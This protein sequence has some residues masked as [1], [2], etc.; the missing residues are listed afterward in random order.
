MKKRWLP[1]TSRKM[2]KAP[3]TAGTAPERGPTTK[4]LDMPKITP[5]TNDNLALTDVAPPARRRVRDRLAA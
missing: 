5:I 1:K 4:E 2:R 3:A